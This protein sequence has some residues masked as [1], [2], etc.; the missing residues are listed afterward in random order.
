MD[1]FSLA[2]GIITLIGASS[3]AVRTFKRIS[4][5]RRAPDLLQSI[6]HELSDLHL[7]ALSIND[8][9]EIAQVNG[10]TDFRANDTRLR[11]SCAQVLDQTKEKVLELQTLIHRRI[12]RPGRAG[13]LKI[14]RFHFLQEEDR[15]IRLQ[16]DLRNARLRMLSLFSYF[17][18][19]EASKIE[20]LLKD[21]HYNGVQ[22]KK[23]VLQA[24]SVLDGGQARLENKLERALNTQFSSQTTLPAARPESLVNPLYE[25]IHVSVARTNDSVS[26][27]TC[28]CRR[29]GWSKT[30]HTYIGCLF[31]GY[32]APLGDRRQKKQCCCEWEREAVFVYYF[33]SWFIRRALLLRAGYSGFAN[34]SFSLSIVQYLPPD[35]NIW[36]MIYMGDVKGIQKLF[37]TGQVSIRAESPNGTGLFLVRSIN[38]RFQPY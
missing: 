5:L 9:M 10:T 17:G 34:P 14:S 4:D 19:R 12:L 7:A 35:H 3:A 6:D 36:T 30:V 28:H 24:L 8:Y 1:P 16:K 33:P 21:L 31:F 29:R 23:D 15:L 37:S 11:Q 38:P 26:Q 13:K 27:R 20:I 32:I 18:L 22:I 2:T 25:K